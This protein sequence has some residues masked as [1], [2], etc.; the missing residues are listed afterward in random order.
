M[1]HQVQPKL[2]E[3]TTGTRLPGVG[4]GQ[5]KHDGVPEKHHAQPVQAEE[6]GDG[7][8]HACGEQHE[9][10]RGQ[11]G[12]KA[13]TEAA[14]NVAEPPG[15]P[16]ITSASVRE[17]PDCVRAQAMPVAVPMMNRMAPDSEAVSTSMG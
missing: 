13:A 2:A 14:M 9:G 15:N 16:V 8:E 11:R 3:V 10:A 12:G 4:P 6:T 1:I 7:A 17:N 5:E